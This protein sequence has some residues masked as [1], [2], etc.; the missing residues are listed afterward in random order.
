VRRRLPPPDQARVNQMAAD[1]GATGVPDVT[2]RAIIVAGLDEQRRYLMQH[3]LG[4]QVHDQAKPH[5]H[6]RHG[7]AEIGWA[8]RAPAATTSAT[9]E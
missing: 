7:R 4:Y 6:G 9:K 8:H 2:D 5:H 3:T 1:L